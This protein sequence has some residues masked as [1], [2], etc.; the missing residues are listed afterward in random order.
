MFS[1]GMAFLPML[2]LAN[3]ASSTRQQQLHSKPV[4]RDHPLTLATLAFMT[5][6]STA[7]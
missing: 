2:V 3:I 1:Q 5:M 7:T 4:H 6:C